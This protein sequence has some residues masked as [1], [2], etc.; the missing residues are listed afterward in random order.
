MFHTV[1]SIIVVDEIIEKAV[2]QTWFHYD[3][4]TS[5]IIITPSVMC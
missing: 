4:V 2:N 1:Y 5:I 3:S